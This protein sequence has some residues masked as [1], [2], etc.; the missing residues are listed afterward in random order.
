MASRRIDDYRLLE[1]MRQS[2][3]IVYV[4]GDRRGMETQIHREV[5]DFFVR[6][7]D[8]IG[9]AK[10]ISL[11]LY[12]PG[13]DLLSGWTIV[14]LL[15]QFCDKLELIV[16]AKALSTGT[17]I[18]LGADVIVMSKQATLGP[19]DPSVNTMLNPQVP[20]GLPNQKVPVSVEAINGFFEL[21]GSRLDGKDQDLSPVVTALMNYVHPLVLG[22]VYRSRAQ[23]RMLAERML[24]RR[25]LPAARKQKIVQ[26]LSSDS[27]SHDYTI[28]RDEAETMGLPVAAPTDAEYDVINR[29]HASIS[30]EL[31]LSDPYNPAVILGPDA[32]KELEVRRALVESV[33]GGVHV[34]VTLTTLQKSAAPVLPPQLQ[35]LPPQIQQQLQAQIP[36]N[37][38]SD[39]RSFEG[40]RYEP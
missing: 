11:L 22:E 34:F 8:K 3:L 7:L 12:T 24:E 5:T 15:R 10:K 32:K 28:D 6:H 21:I 4:T 16:P 39:V 33:D 2:K 1:G 17:L 13:G 9:K 23:I 20:G 27:G 14:R 19:I 29:I 36:Q 38:V 31:Q 37:V 26:F 25:R 18:A 40:W 30:G 35:G